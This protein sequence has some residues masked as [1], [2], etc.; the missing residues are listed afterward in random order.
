MSMTTCGSS[1]PCRGAPQDP[2]IARA[3]FLPGLS[4]LVGLKFIVDPNAYG[5]ASAN[6][7]I[8][9]FEAIM[10]PQYVATERGP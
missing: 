1:K 3:M 7:D 6:D 9:T 2:S 10:V 5:K 4:I 8:T